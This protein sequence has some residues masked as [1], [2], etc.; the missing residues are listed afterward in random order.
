MKH[1]NRS[2][3]PLSNPVK[4]VTR[5]SAKACVCVRQA[6]KAQSA[7]VQGPCGSANRQQPTA[8]SPRRHATKRPAFYCCLD[9]RN[10]SM[11]VFNRVTI[12]YP[13]LNPIFG[14]PKKSGRVRV[15]LLNTRNYLKPEQ[16]D[17]KFRVYLNAQS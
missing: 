17:P 12:N 8:N 13:N 3:W 5:H 10:S 4:S 9:A 7:T 6:A 15:R 16:P 14:Y 1:S 2:T 11:P